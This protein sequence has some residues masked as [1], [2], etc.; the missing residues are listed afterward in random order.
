MRRNARIDRR[1][2]RIAAGGEVHHS[3][4]GEVRVVVRF[5]RELAGA[6]AHREHSSVGKRAPD[7]DRFEEI[8]EEV[9]FRLDEHN[10]RARRHRVGPLDVERG[11]LRPSAVGTRLLAVRVH[12]LEYVVVRVQRIG[13]R[14]GGQPELA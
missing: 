13:R 8:G 3:I 1:A 10:L 2:A 12:D 6:P 5:V 4:V 7:V 9:R 14:F 11:F